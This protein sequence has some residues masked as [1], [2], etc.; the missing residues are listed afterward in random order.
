LI[1]GSGGWKFSIAIFKIFLAPENF[2][3]EKRENVER[4]P[5]DKA[6]DKSIPKILS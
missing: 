3:M 4:K 5:T 2:E 6:L 1:G